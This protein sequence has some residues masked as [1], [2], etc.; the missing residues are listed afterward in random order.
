[1]RLPKFKLKGKGTAHLKFRKHKKSTEHLDNDAVREMIKSM[2]K[3]NEDKGKKDEGKMDEE[4]KE[5]DE[6]TAAKGKN[7]VELTEAEKEEKLTKKMERKKTPER[8]AANNWKKHTGLGYSTNKNG[9]RA[10]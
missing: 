4:G 3:K 6:K 1:M 9:P 2:K 8:R 7:V 10:F 5:E